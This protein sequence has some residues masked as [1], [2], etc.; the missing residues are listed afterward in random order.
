MTLNLEKYRKR[1]LEEKARV[2]MERENIR[3]DQGIGDA[4]GDLA[5]LDNN[6]PADQGTETYEKEKDMALISMLDTQLTQIRD[7]VA[8]IDAGTY[9]TCERCGK[10]IPEAR[11]NTVPFATLCVEDQEYIERTQ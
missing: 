4:V 8:R 2:E 10:P 1:I 6:H 5:N 11:L 7:A 9:G 3:G